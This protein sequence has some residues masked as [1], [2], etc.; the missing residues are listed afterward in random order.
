MPDKAVPRTPLLG[1]FAL[2]KLAASLFLL[3]FSAR[4]LRQFA[5]V[6]DSSYSEDK[7]TKSNGCDSSRQFLGVYT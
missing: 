6:R 4:H 7:S 3:C 1:A 5:T 2:S